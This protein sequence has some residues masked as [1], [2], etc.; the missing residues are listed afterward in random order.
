MTEKEKRRM[1]LAELAA[2]SAPRTSGRLTCPNC[3]CPEFTA[4]RTE[5]TISSV[6]RYKKCS[7]CGRKF[8]TV[9]AQERVL[10]AVEKPTETIQPDDFCGD[11]IV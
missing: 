1:T 7:H 5:Y 8:L 10:R 9:Q 2:Q 3:G 6:V 4:Y 11:D